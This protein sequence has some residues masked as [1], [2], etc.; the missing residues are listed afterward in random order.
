MEQDSLDLD[1]ARRHIG[2]HLAQVGAEVVPLEEA[3]Y[4]WPT[5]SVRARSPQPGF[6][7]STRDGFVIP[8]GGTVR[9]ARG[10][11]FRLD[12]EI[13]AGSVGRRRLRNGAAYRIMT[14]ALIPVGG[15]RVIPQEDCREVDGCILI[16]DPVLRQET[17]CIRK[18][19]SE[20]RKGGVVIA[21][22]SPI[23]PEHQALL[24]ATGHTTV[25][26]RRRP[27]VRFFCTG[28]EL[29]TSPALEEEGLKV[30][31]NRYLLASLIHLA[32][33]VP[34]YLGNVADSEGDLVDA[35]RRIDPE[36]TEMILTTGGVGPGRYDLLGEAF[37]KAGGRVI[38]RSLRIRPGKSTLFGVLGRSL[39]F[40]LPG[41]PPAVAVLFNELV[42]PALISLQ[43]RKK[44]R[45][46]EI[47]ALLDTPLVLKET[48]VPSLAAAKIA[49]RGGRTRV[50]RAAKTEAADGFI[51]FSGRKRRYRQNDCVRVHLTGRFL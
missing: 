43:S 51:F 28:S 4:R 46:V 27:R 1:A 40:G 39:F 21:A 3:L 50:R 47:R 17:T 12:G 19:G 7:Q 36:T 31:G 2:S 16:S 37:V 30:S 8:S 34:E 22:G 18:K 26:V 15:V 11:S 44:C 33:G 29:V 32:G 48:G 20:I 24:A 41:P 23:K 42:G 49:V 10:Y 38:Y 13:P 25:M 35:F 14:G 9:S 6:D 45:P 5:A